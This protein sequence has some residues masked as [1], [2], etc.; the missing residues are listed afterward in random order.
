[1][2]AWSPLRMMSRWSCVS[3]LISVNVWMW[4]VMRVNFV[5]CRLVGVDDEV[6]QPIPVWRADRR[7]EQAFPCTPFPAVPVK[8]WRLIVSVVLGLTGVGC[9]LVLAFLE[10]ESCRLWN[11]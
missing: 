8:A 5:N 10:C 4:K 3:V 7:L 1:M 11:L 6:W 2:F 9:R